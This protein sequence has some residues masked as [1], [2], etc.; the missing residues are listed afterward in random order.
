MR[1]RLVELRSFGKLSIG[2]NRRL[3]GP[4]QAASVHLGRRMEAVVDNEAL[5]REQLVQ[6]LRGRG[7][8]MPVQQA[9]ADFPMDR[10][11]EKFPNGTYSTWAL[12]EHLRLTQLDILDY[13]RNPNYTPR[14]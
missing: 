13:C 9:L 5:I 14:P 11:N 4:A 7:A 10:I 12:L 1:A 3:T 6:R 8:H 2:W